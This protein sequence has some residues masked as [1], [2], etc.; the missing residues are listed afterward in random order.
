M[1]ES[2]NGPRGSSSVPTPQ[3]ESLCVCPVRRLLWSSDSGQASSAQAIQAPCPTLP[4]VRWW[5]L[6]AQHRGARL[7]CNPNHL[8][9][10]LTHPLDTLARC[11]PQFGAWRRQGRGGHQPSSG[12]L[13]QQWV[14]SGQ[15]DECLREP[16]PTVGSGGCRKCCVNAGA[17][18]AAGRGEAEVWPPQCTHLEENSKL[19]GS[20]GS[21]SWF[22]G[23]RGH[24]KD[25][26][27]LGQ[28]SGS[29]GGTHSLPFR[30][31][32][33]CRRKRVQAACM[34]ALALR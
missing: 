7:Y 32:V 19:R 22:R 15:G 23:G 8:G 28:G 5:R 1:T 4:G 17:R 25:G 31:R 16:E 13:S 34:E 14:A 3:Q 24:R 30:S 33:C 10:Q 6:G 29:G 2:P 12:D 9:L 27:G 20:Q 18:E 11:R 21:R 26:V